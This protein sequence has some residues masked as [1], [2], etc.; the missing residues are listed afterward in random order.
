MSYGAAAKATS[1]TGCTKA[2]WWQKRKP[3]SAMMSSCLGQSLCSSKMLQLLAQYAPSLDSYCS[4][5]QLFL[6]LQ[7]VKEMPSSSQCSSVRGWG[8]QGNAAVK[9]PTFYAED[10]AASANEVWQRIHSDPL[11]AVCFLSL[12]HKRGFNCHTI[13][14]H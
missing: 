1:L 12:T 14:H 11:F 10:T 6:W 4:P 7:R 3:T 8:M 13:R 9:L 5:K 2:V